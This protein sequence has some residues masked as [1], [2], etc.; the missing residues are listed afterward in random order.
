M[1]EI[2][3][4]RIELKTKVL[5]L[6]VKDFGDSPVDIEDLLQVDANAV[7]ADMVTFPVI[8]NRIALIKAEID[9]LLRETQL[10]CSIFE[11]GL[12]KKHKKA[13]LTLGEKATEGAIDTAVKLDPDYKIKKLQVI[14]VQRH[15]DII[16]GLYWSAKSKDKKLDAISAKIKPEEFENEILEGTVNSVVIRIQKN[17]FENRR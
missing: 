17:H 13:M 3:K 7:V 15:A 1:K 11:A 8:F 6:E 16:D 2:E 4:V 9:G 5:I 12:Y 10:D 14:N